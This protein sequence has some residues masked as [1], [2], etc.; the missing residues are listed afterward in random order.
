VT[1]EGE[2]GDLVQVRAA[3]DRAS[4]PTIGP[5]TDV[6]F[7]T[8]PIEEAQVGRRMTAV[9]DADTAAA[10]EARVKDHL[11]GVGGYEVRAAEPWPPELA[12]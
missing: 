6:R 8:E 7:A 1:I 10:A 12:P 11:P 9:L 5:V 2:G 4:I 3:L